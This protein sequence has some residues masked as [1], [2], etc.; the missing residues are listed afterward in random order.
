MAFG[1][2]EERVAVAGAVQA[3]AMA[4]EGPRRPIPERAD[5]AIRGS[6]MASLSIR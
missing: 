2:G 6:I 1:T 4:D 3:P 5:R